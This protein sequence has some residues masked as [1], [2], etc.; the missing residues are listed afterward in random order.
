MESERTENGRKPTLKWKLM[1]AEFSS[2]RTHEKEM[3]ARR[4]VKALIAF[5]DD[6]LIF[7]VSCS[8]KC[9]KRNV[10]LKCGC[11]RLVHVGPCGS[12]F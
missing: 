5:G 6:M 8:R 7:D 3:A 9:E 2:A 12:S 4:A 11:Y 10:R 1:F